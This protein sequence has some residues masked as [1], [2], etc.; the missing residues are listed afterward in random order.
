MA[1]NQNVFSSNDDYS[2]ENAL[3]SHVVSAQSTKFSAGEI[4]ANVC[5]L[6]LPSIIGILP[7]QIPF[8]MIL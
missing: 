5:Q 1:G 4:P 7:I 3:G 8:W 6:E 2:L